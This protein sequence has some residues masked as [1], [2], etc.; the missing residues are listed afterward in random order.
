M[1]VSISHSTL[2]SFSP[3]CSLSRSLSIALSLPSFFFLS[4]SIILWGSADSRGMIE[5]GLVER[6]G[7][8]SANGTLSPVGHLL[9]LHSPAAPAVSVYVCACVCEYLPDPHPRVLFSISVPLFDF[10]FPTTFCFFL[11]LSIFSLNFFQHSHFD[12]LSFLENSHFNCSLS[13]SLKGLILTEI[14]Q[15]VTPTFQSSSDHAKPD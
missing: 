14:Y 2:Y 4:F 7:K 3:I 9:T 15:C 1:Q 12:S 13:R 11:Q 6:R 5:E 10:A 8:W